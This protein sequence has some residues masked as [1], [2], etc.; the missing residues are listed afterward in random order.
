MRS[1]DPVWLKF[2]YALLHVPPGTGKTTFAKLYGRLLKNLG[3][4]SSGDVVAKTASDFM[5]SHVG[6]SQKT[7]NQILECAKGKVL[8]I[9]EA[10]VL[11]DNLYGKQVLDTLVEKV[12][13]SPS[14]DI[15]VL[16]LGYEQPMLH[17]IKEQNPGLKRR[18]PE[19]HSFYF[20]DYSDDELLKVLELNLHSQGVKATLDF[21]EKA[22]DKLRLQR[23][24][25]NFGNA[26]S[27]QLVI[28]GAI[29][30]AAT[31]DKTSD[32]CVLLAEDIEKS[33]ENRADR[34]EDPMGK[35]D[36][37]FAVDGIKASFEKKR[38]AW[39]V[40]RREGSETPEI[41]HFVFRGAP[42]E[43]YSPKGDSVARSLHGKPLN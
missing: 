5:G 28:S 36:K 34:K 24:Q 9:D 11:D 26:G 33:G 16:L 37:L 38:K 22:L 21:K 27:V 15:S 29:Q 23:S 7:T 14:D 1:S 40:A 17:M 12:Q 10:Y 39:A 13:G 3:F 18:F 4:L 19:D 41:G 42:G 8:I 6:E 30:R 20:D 35:F 31:R 32:D 2:S 25:S 43:C